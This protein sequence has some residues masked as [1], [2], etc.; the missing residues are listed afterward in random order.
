VLFIPDLDFLPIP[1][2]GSRGQKALDPR[3]GSATLVVGCGLAYT[4]H[5]LKKLN[6]EYQAR[7]KY[8][9]EKFYFLCHLPI[10]AWI[11]YKTQQRKSHAWVLYNTLTQILVTDFSKKFLSYACMECCGSGDVHPG[12]RIFSIPDSGSRG[13]K[14]TGS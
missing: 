9:I 14:G 8:Y 12:I 13:Q 11:V 4:A 3:S 5:T 7:L 1:D 6:G 10:Q 2:P